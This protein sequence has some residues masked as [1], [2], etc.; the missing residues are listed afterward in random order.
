ME[1]TNYSS[2]GV[3]NAGKGKSLW[4]QFDFAVVAIIVVLAILLGAL[5]NLRVADERKVK[6]FGAP[7]DWDDLETTE[8]VTP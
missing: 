7:V 3:E 2:C 4:W 8:D 1:Q 6:L 5:N